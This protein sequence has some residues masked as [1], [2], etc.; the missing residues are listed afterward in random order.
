[1]GN[2]THLH[3][4]LLIKNI[5]DMSTNLNSGLVG[6][7]SVFELDHLSCLVSRLRQQMNL[8]STSQE[9]PKE[10]VDTY[11]NYGRVPVL[12]VHSL[13]RHYLLKNPELAQGK[14]GISPVP[15]T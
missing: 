4:G 14:E 10:R 15:L 1:M 12:S 11:L 9:T 7:N 2:Y 13:I 8:D 3:A 6:L 5:T